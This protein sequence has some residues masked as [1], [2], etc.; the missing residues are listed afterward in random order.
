MLCLCQRHKILQTGWAETTPDTIQISGSQPWC[1]GTL[2]CRELVPPIVA[3]PHSLY[4]LHQLG[5][6][7]DICN[8]KKGCREQKR[9]GNTDMDRN[10]FVKMHNAMCGIIMTVL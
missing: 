10:S 6:P 4:L 3:F 1:R 7:P 9:L 8:S 5:V 2:G